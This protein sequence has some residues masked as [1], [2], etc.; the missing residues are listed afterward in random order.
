M[1]GKQEK[2]L[3]RIIKFAG[4]SAWVKVLMRG[5]EPEDPNSPLARILHHSPTYQPDVWNDHFTCISTNCYAYACDD[6]KDHDH[7]PQPGQAANKH[8]YDDR[9]NKHKLLE[10]CQEDGLIQLNEN[11][12][13]EDGMWLVALSVEPGR[14]DNHHLDYHWHRLD[15][16]GTWSHKPGPSQ[17]LNHD[18]S[19][20]TILC[21][22]SCNRGSYQR[23]LSYFLVPGKDFTVGEK[24]LLERQK[25]NAHPVNNKRSIF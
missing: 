5:H 7:K 17:V 2:A 22:E 20:R 21:P 1:A 18:E 24:G 15:A 8:S 12:K 11:T 9:R 14:D 13:V 3:D 23:F 19:G 6:P 25:R 10:L 16:N 4:S